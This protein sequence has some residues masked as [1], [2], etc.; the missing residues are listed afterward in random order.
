MVQL[1]DVKSMSFKTDIWTLC[2]GTVSLISLTV[3]RVKSDTYALQSGV[4][5]VKV[6]FIK[7][8]LND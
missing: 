5:Q 3:H 1:K 2:A 7:E 4:L 6:Q 8:M